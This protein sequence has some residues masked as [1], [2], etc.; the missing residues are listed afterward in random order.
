[1]IS[2]TVLD[3]DLH[4]FDE[5]LKKYPEEI[6]V[7]YDTGVDG[8][9]IIQVIIDISEVMIPSVMGAIGLMLTYKS[10]KKTEHMQQKELELKEKEYMLNSRNKEE[11]EIRVSSNGE[12]TVL[13]KSNDL[14]SNGEIKDNVDKIIKK[15][16]EAIESESI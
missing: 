8:L 1:M 4:F 13:I 11:V 5:L 10:Q 14:R 6:T 7:S 15:I 3:E 16:K 12:T 2:I 9:S